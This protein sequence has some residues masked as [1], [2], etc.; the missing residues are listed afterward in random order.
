M[1]QLL[2]E[3]D[4]TLAKEIQSGLNKLG[5]NS[6][7][8]DGIVGPKTKLE[9]AKW[10]ATVYQGEPDYIGT[11][12]LELFR[13]KVAS[14]QSKQLVTKSQ[15][16]SVYG[17]PITDAQLSDL[18]ACLNRFGINTNSRIRHFLA[19]TAHESGGLRWLRELASGQAYEG[20]RDLGNT[21]KEDGRRF[22]GAGVIQLT[23]RAN[24]QAFSNY[25]KD[26][27]VMEGVNYVASVYPFTSAGFWWH[28]NKM[29]SLIDGGASVTQVTRRVNGG[30]NGLA[31]RQKYYAKA[32]KVFP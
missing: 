11:G 2:T 5:F 4:S 19:Q 9:W 16:E 23:G 6:G 15:A 18:N 21:Q 26:P 14:F 8:V 1:K 28:N 13:E 10:K 24:Y 12:S 20:R 30:T 3:I 31:D 27:R 17:R 22:K 32:I 7:A 29:N 25:I